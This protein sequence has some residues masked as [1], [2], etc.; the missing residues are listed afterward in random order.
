MPICSRRKDRSRSVSE[1]R[2]NFHMAR[3]TQTDEIR[4]MI[5]LFSRFKFAK[6][7]AM[8]N[9]N[10]RADIFCAALACPVVSLNCNLPAMAPCA[11]TKCLLST[12]IVRCILAAEHFCSVLA[13][14]FSS[15]ESIRISG[16]SSKPWLFLKLQA[17][18]YAIE[19]YRFSPSAVS[20]S[21]HAVGCERTAIPA[22]PSSHTIHV[23]DHSYAAAPP[24]AV[25]TASASRFARWQADKSAARKAITFDPVTFAHNIILHRSQQQGMA[26]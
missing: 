2:L 6:W 13:A 7:L 19:A 15:T 9:R 22:W 3:L 20:R 21:A 10:R 8:M 24:S 14:A 17:A 25:T 1:S 26:I 18:V 11:A 16:L 5:R 23:I 4:R 12:N